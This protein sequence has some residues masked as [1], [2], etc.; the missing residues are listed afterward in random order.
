[1]KLTPDGLDV[2]NYASPALPFLNLDPKD[3]QLALK[4]MWNYSYQFLTTDDVDLGTST[5]TPA[6]SR[7]TERCPSSAIPPTTSAG[8]S[9]PV[10]STSIRSRRNRIRTATARSRAL[11]DPGAFDLKGVGALGNRYV[12]SAKQDD[13]WLYLPS[14][15]RV[16]RLSTAQRS[17]ALRPGH[18]RRQLLRLRR[19]VAWMEWK[20][21]A[22]RT[23]SPR[24]AKNYP[25]KWN[26]K[27]D[28]AFDD[29]WEKRKVYVVEGVS[30]LPSTPTRSAFSTSTRKAG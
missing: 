27:V 19:H 18:R 7:I 15:P 17:D 12:D 20:Y 3:P 8:S 1:V 6:A 22:R 28:W 5:P 9:G 29:V 21:P 23:S 16:R 2:K 14:L 30:K 10:A 24:S 4:I 26:E 11:S 13:S 25:V